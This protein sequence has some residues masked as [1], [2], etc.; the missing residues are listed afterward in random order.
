M[1]DGKALTAADN[2]LAAI[3]S[4]PE[5]LQAVPVDVVERL[6]AMDREMRADQAR[7]LFA[8]AFN[9]VQSSMEPVRRTKSNSHTGS[10]YAAAEAVVNM[11]AP[12]LA[13]E[14]FSWSVSTGE[15]PGPEMLRV[16]LKLRHGGGHEETHHLD[17]PID[18]KGIGGKATKTAL[19]GMGS[20]ITYCQRYLLCSVF[21][22]ELADDR[23]GNPPEDAATVTD[24]QAANLK[25][26]CDEVGADLGAFLKVL[27]VPK[28]ED[29]PASKYAGAVRRLEA[30]R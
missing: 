20:T 25:A 9:R 23:D 22:V 18:N 5:R 10:M 13:A 4:D 21:G 29:L 17:A 14:G 7:Q 30:K 3:L 19:H 8:D 26:L 16:V 15:P 11:L 1:S 24:E 28:L 27:K 12:I 2:P 6:F